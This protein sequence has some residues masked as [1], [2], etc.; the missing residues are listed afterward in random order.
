MFCAPLSAEQP[1]LNGPP[2]QTFLSTGSLLP[3]SVD[4]WDFMS[5][6]YASGRDGP[7]CLGLYPILQLFSCLPS[8]LKGQFL[9]PHPPH[10]TSDWIF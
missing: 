9:F 4:S 6:L 8:F 1:I 3:S 10:L 7:A 5:R 2:G